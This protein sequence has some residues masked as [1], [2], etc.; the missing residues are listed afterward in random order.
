LLTLSITVNKY[1][2]APQHKMWHYT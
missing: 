1:L 2:T